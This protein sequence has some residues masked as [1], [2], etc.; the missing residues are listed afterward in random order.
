LL[1][2]ELTALPWDVRKAGDPGGAESAMVIADDEGGSL[3]TALL[4][5]AEKVAPMDLSFAQGGGDSEHA[6]LAGGVDANGD[7]HG[8]IE[9]DAVTADFFV[10]G[11]EDKVGK[12][13]FAERAGA[14]DLELL[15]EL[16]AGAAD[17][18]GGDLQV[19]GQLGK[20]GGDAA[21]GD[22]LDVHF[23]NGH[24]QGAFAAQAAFE[25]GGIKVHLPAD[26]RNIDLELAQTGLQRLLLKAV[27]VAF[28]RVGA[29]VGRSFQGFRAFRLHGMVEEQTDAFEQTVGT[30]GGEV[31]YDF[32]EQG[33]VLVWMGHFGGCLFAK[34]QQANLARPS[35][36]VRKAR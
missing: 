17:L 24:G 6:T 20:N 7:E 27:G 25:S 19:A 32:V 15:I 1:E 33:I 4:E 9:N 18:G 34:T 2:V 28:A 22:A 29:F 5:R 23:G 35:H 12:S 30:I 21:G 11:I 8:A 3:Q 13:H 36:A 16:G 10:A 14:P 31:I 26:L